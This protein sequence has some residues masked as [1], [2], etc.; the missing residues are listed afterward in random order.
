MN[1]TDLAATESTSAV[2]SIDDSEATPRAP[3]TGLSGVFTGSMATI[4]SN[5]L[6]AVILGILLAWAL[7]TGVGRRSKDDPAAQ[8]D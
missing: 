3:L 1:R 7:V 4:R 2:D 6:Q 5:L 8:D